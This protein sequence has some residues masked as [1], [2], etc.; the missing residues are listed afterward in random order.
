MGQTRNWLQLRG[1]EEVALKDINGCLRWR[2]EGPGDFIFH[3]DTGSIAS[4]VPLH[5]NS[6]ASLRWSYKV[7]ATTG[8][9]FTLLRQSLPP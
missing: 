3:L 2:M 4:K 8:S 6:F 5:G 7:C 1:E 9:G